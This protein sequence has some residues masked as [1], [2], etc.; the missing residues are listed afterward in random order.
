MRLPTTKNEYVA[1]VAGTV[2]REWHK[3]LA[4]VGCASTGALNTPLVKSTGSSILSVFSYGFLSRYGARAL[5]K[6]NAPIIVV[7]AST[8][9]PGACGSTRYAA[10]AVSATTEM[11]VGIGN[12]VF[13]GA[14]YDSFKLGLQIST[15]GGIG[16][17]QCKLSEDG[18]A[19]WG[20]AKTLISD[21]VL[22]DKNITIRLVDDGD[23][24]EGNVF[25]CDAVGPATDAAGLANALA[26]LN[27]F[28]TAHAAVVVVGQEWADD[29]FADMTAEVEAAAVGGEINTNTYTVLLN[30]RMQALSETADE[31]REAIEQ[32]VLP[33]VVNPRVMR[34]F[35][36]VQVRDSITRTRPWRNLAEELAICI[37]KRSDMRLDLMQPAVGLL[38]DVAAANIVTE[39]TDLLVQ[40]NWVCVRELPGRDGK[41]YVSA[42]LMNAAG[43][44]E[45]DLSM[46]QYRQIFD[47]VLNQMRT[48]SQNFYGKPMETNS[49]TGIITTSAAQKFNRAFEAHVGVLVDGE[50]IL[51][52]KVDTSTSYRDREVA[53]LAAKFNISV[54]A[55]I[56]RVELY[57][58]LLV[59][60]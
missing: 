24:V 31:Y 7:R 15:G 3:Q 23:F 47:A 60:I 45:T 35:G 51:A 36:Q 17:A 20:A 8:V 14:A 21:I 50:V 22:A 53:V 26:A 42:G 9:T 18:G 59:G 13:E 39:T 41:F 54:A 1:D 38:E 32:I 48:Y 37:C 19:T 33:G 43:P 34:A 16:T 58:T 25:W 27:A 55:S 10:T 52:F 30:S 44:D 49:T 46:L 12:V 6:L 5:S 40:Q 11:P 28:T 29:V 57:G 56:G 4:I 2:P